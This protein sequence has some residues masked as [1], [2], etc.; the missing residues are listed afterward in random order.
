MAWDFADVGYDLY[1]SEPQERRE[2]A[3]EFWREI[4]EA[5]VSDAFE[6]EQERRARAYNR[7]RT[8]LTFAGVREMLAHE[9][10]R[11][12]RKGLYM[13]VSRSTVLGRWN[14][15]KRAE[16]H[17]RRPPEHEPLGQWEFGW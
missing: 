3:R 5:P 6:D 8:D 12:K 2:S 9:Q 17:G 4:A 11:A 15:I 1:G 16:F 7:F 14:E 13:F 10:D